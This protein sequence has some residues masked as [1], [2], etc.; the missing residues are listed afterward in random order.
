MRRRST[1]TFAGFLSALLA[2][3]ACAASSIPE[4]PALWIE[5]VTG[6]EFLY[7]V[8]ARFTMGSGE[9]VPGRQIDEVLHDVNLTRGFYLGRFEVT[10]EEW[11]EVMGNDPSQFSACGSRCPVETVNFF[12]IQQFIQRLGE[13]SAGHRFRLPTEAEWEFACRA[14]TTTPFSTGENLTSEQANFDGKYPYDGA[15]AGIFRGSPAPVGSY[16]PNPWGFHDMHGNVWEWCQDWYGPYQEGEVIDPLGPANGEL[17]VIR[18]GSWLF[19]GNSAR[20]AL[21]YTH[22]PE[23]DGFSL[24]FRLVRE[25]GDR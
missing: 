2:L 9:E 18:G 21:R 10:Q 22:A 15:P 17:R 16:P 11:V 12:D 5:P 19:D 14:G 3:T 8:P 6:M 7:V 25:V 20:S 13:R 24:G 1:I 23:D 4:P